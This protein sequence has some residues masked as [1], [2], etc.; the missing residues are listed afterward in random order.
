MKYNCG[1]DDGDNDI[2]ED[3]N[4]DDNAA[5]GSESDG[6]IFNPITVPRSCLGLA[7]EYRA[8]MAT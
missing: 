8:T 6:P 1:D 4:D 3:G 2:N 7:E 5:A